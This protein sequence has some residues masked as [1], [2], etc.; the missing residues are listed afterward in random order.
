MWI[1]S[2]AFLFGKAEFWVFGS[3]FHAL[4]GHGMGDFQRTGM[5]VQTIRGWAAAVQ[6]ISYDGVSQSC[7]MGTDL[8]GAS[9]LRSSLDQRGLLKTLQDSQVGHG[10]LAAVRVNRCAVAVTNI[11]T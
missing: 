7:Q 10:W 5:Q 11:G 1:I 2:C 3:E 6:L 9:G 8:M 4:A